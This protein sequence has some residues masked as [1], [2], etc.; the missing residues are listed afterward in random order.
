MLKRP[1]RI[2]IIVLASLGFLAA[3]G[4]GQHSLREKARKLI[5]EA[6]PGDELPKGVTIQ[7]WAHMSGQKEPKTLSEHWE[8]STGQVHSMVVDRENRDDKKPTRYKSNDF[9]TS[10][11]MFA[12]KQ[13]KFL[14]IEAR[15]GMGEPTL[16]AGTPFKT[17]GRIITLFIDGKVA[18]VSA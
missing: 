16:L 10:G 3:N 6:K 4:F 8:F 15:E 13:G 1:T 5:N 12:L 17:G 7:V 18:L 9:D 11:L 2:S 14:K